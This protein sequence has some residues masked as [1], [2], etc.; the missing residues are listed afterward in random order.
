LKADVGGMVLA[1]PA[2]NKV[3]KPPTGFEDGPTFVYINKNAGA[4]ANHW[5]KLRLSDEH[6]L[7]RFAIGARVVVSGPGVSAAR[8]VRAG[9]CAGSASSTDLVIGLGRDGTAD[10]VDIE[11]PTK[12]R[13]ARHYALPQARDQLVCIERQRGVVACK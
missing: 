13:A 9:G 1:I 12:Q 2:P 7:N 5:L 10:A 3:M 8:V 6:G 11:W 4:G